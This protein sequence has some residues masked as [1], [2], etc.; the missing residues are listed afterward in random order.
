MK[1]LATA[2]RRSHCWALLLIGSMLSMWSAS[3]AEVAG[4]VQDSSGRQISGASV[5][6]RRGLI[7]L[8]TSSDGSGK[9]RF[10]GIETGSYRLEVIHS[11]FQ[12][13]SKNLEI[14]ESGN[15][16]LRVELALA[17]LLE[18]VVVTAEA[19]G[20][21]PESSTMGTKLDLPLLDTPQA[22]GVVSRALIEDRGLL[23]VAEAAD[24]VSSVR[25]SPGYG[26]L[27]S[28]NFC[29]FDDQA[30]AFLR[31][32]RAYFSRK[33][34]RLEEMEARDIEHR[35]RF[36]PDTSSRSTWSERVA[37]PLGGLSL[38]FAVVSMTFIWRIRHFSMAQNK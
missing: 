5:A 37:L 30:E 19:D 24:N 31:E 14:R 20:Y 26:G 28:G 1:N 35:P 23:R 29:E 25:A 36:Q 32:W 33:V 16:P 4:E 18:S 38:W 17:G 22:I 7:Q 6:L 2:K 10:T 13:F 11:G 27:S 9:F 3:G 34:W 8:R 21:R 12:A 15:E